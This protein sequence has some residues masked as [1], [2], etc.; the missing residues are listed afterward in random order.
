MSAFSSFF[1]LGRAALSAFHGQDLTFQPRDDSAP[2]ETVRALVGA[3]DVSMQQDESD[4]T[5]VQTR[6][7]QVPIDVAEGGPSEFA[8]GGKYTIDGEIWTVELEQSRDSRTRMS[9]LLLTR[10]MRLDSGGRAERIARSR[11]D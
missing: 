10:P 4:Q 7:L 11:S 9:V 5:K 1:A 8:R 2:Q 6:T 3:I